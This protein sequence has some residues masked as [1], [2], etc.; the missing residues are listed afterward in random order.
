MT[1]KNIIDDSGADIVECK[2]SADLTAFCFN[3]LISA[4]K[5][6]GAKRVFLPAGNTPTSL[7]KMMEEKKGS[8]HSELSGVTF[9]QIDEV[10]TG[11]QRGVFKKFFEEHLPSFT[12][13][14]EFV[15]DVDSDQVTG[16]DIAILG[17]GLNGHVG[18]HEPHMDSDFSF[19]TVDLSDTT[20][21]NLKLEP[22]ARG[23]SYGLGHFMAAKKVLMISKGASKAL[24]T[25][26]TLQGKKGLPSSQFLSHPDFTLVGDPDSFSLISARSCPVMTLCDS[27][28]SLIAG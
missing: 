23:Q 21:K 1:T 8:G 3:W 27:E 17:V 15:G 13:Q 10:V 26:E 4:I 18:F 6:T 12:G 16:A 11:S 24:I 22:T 7:Y 20:I 2:N 9:V 14:F 25:A 5:E 19:G 28:N